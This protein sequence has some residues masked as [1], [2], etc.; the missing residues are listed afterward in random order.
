MILYFS[1][2]GNSEYIAKNLAGLLGDT[3]HNLF[4][5][6]NENKKTAFSSEKPYVLCTPTYSWR[7]PR[8]LQ[9]ALK[10]ITFNG[11]KNMYVIMTC[12]DSAGNAEKYLKTDIENIKMN[13]L[14]LYPILMPEN[15]IALFNVPESEKID[16]MLKN[17]LS[18]LNDAS[19]YITHNKP[20]PDVK[21][22]LLSKFLSAFVN[23]IF[24]TLIVKDKK[25]YVKDNCISCGICAE[26]CIM[27][28]ITYV[29][30]KPVWNGNCTHCM[31]CISKCPVSAIEYGTATKNKERYL[32]K[33]HV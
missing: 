16:V 15:Y 13:F 12:G 19:G 20:F 33:N 2:T 17:A 22:G 5:V 30:K 7:I 31:A 26:V 24:Y 3:A 27:S 10:N 8:I 21:S 32:L 9:S 6:I 11:S 29:D 1:A 23:P 14:G 28:N 25:F 4:D 18:S